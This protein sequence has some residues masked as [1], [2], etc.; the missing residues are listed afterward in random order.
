VISD[1]PVFSAHILPKSSS[2]LTMSSSPK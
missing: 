2:I 1:I